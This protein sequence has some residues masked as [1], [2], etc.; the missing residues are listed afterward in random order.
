MAIGVSQ[1]CRSTTNKLAPLLPVS[2]VTKLIGHLEGKIKTVEVEC[3]LSES[4]NIIGM[5]SSCPER[6][7]LTGEPPW[8]IY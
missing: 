2:N 6:L 5:Q 3:C 1:H 7:I 8:Y 4:A